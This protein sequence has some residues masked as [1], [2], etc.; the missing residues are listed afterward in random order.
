MNSPGN[1]DVVRRSA[2]QG[3]AQLPAVTVLIAAHD[4]LLLLKQS[5]ASALAQNYPSFEVLVVDDGSDEPTRAWLRSAEERFERLRVI[6]SE[7]RGVGAARATGVTEA[8][9]DLVCILDS[10][11]A[12]MPHALRRLSQVF[13]E[14][15]DSVLVYTQIRELR[16]NG[17]IVVRAYPTFTTARAMLWATMLKPRV[18]FKHSGTM[19]RRSVAIGLGSYDRELPCK[20]DIDFYLRFMIAGH[21]PRLVAEPLVDFRM[22]K[23]SI[24]RDRGLGLRVWFRLIDRYGPPN[25]V[26]RLGIKAI[27]GI[28]E[29]L[30][31][32]YI[33]LTG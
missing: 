12:L 16:P 1:I 22:H 10:D 11:D 27:R 28:S 7:H 26:A 14:H 18:P 32:L 17:K 2:R 3:A 30:K 19:F 23:H 5:V 8:R 9:G 33:E 21:R 29:G 13:E 24:S 15:P 4:R 31:Q 20:V 6:F 25:P